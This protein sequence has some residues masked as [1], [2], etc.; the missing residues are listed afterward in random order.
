MAIVG[1]ARTAPSSTT[2]LVMG[3]ELTFPVLNWGP[4]SGRPVLLLHG[5]PQ[6]PLSWA[7]VAETLAEEGFLAIA[8]FQRGYTA[9]ARP[10]NSGE[11][12]FPQFVSDAIA[13]TN[14]MG[15]A[16]IDVVGFGLGAAQ[17]WMLA[18]RHQS[19]VRSL[20]AIR[21]P[22]PA[23]FALTMQSSSEQKEQWARIQ[24]AVGGR[25]PDEKASELLANNAGGLRHFLSSSGLPEPFLS[26]YVSRLQ[27]PGAL[28]AALQ[29][30]QA[31][32]LTEFAAVPAVATPTLYI[33][34]EGPALTR[35]A[36]EATRDYVTKQFTAV[37]APEAGHFVLELEP[38][39][40]TNPLL[41]HLKST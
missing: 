16:T 41:R 30:N 14:S 1:H 8:P 9:S 18:A 33:W 22:H 27:E 32:S 20:T 36:A 3:N 6:E 5:F 17:A 34:S 24:R 21:Y 15:F 40:V 23:A 7:A 11:Y 31:I 38:R 29:W 37:C 13:I 12:T 26:R 28:A 39:A 35:A 2:S 19:R 25:S 10:Q 4:A